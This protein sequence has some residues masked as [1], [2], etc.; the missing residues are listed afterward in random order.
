MEH[1][2]LF[3]Y[4]LKWLIPF[5]CAGAFTSFIIPFWNKYKIGQKAALQQKWDE[6]AQEFKTEMASFEANTSKEES[7]LSREL[8]ELKKLSDDRDAAIESRLIEIQEQLIEKIDDSTRGVREAVL[9]S[10]L[11]D[12]LADG[13]IY[14]ERG[15]ITLEQLT[16]YENRYQIYKS[17]GGNGHMD[18]W[19]AK[20]RELSNN[21]PFDKEG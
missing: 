6:C 8:K 20:I 21:P 12:L 4:F 17:L 19:I 9:Q 11:R 15:Y 3:E 5:L 10:H 14:I 16:D 1:Y 2:D 7:R 18:P 13:K